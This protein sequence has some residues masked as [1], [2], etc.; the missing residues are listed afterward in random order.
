M[1][2]THKMPVVLI[3]NS[4]KYETEATLKLF[5]APH[6]LPFPRIFP[7]RRAKASS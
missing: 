3:G 6:D 2:N 5:S 1:I 7:T 4:F